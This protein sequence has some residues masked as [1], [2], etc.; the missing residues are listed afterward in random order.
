MGSYMREFATQFTQFN[1]SSGLNQINSY[2]QLPSS[3]KLNTS[4]VKNNALLYVNTIKPY[5]I[6]D[7]T[8]FSPL[9]LQ[10]QN[11]IYAPN[12]TVSNFSGFLFICNLG[13]ISNLTF[14]KELYKVIILLCL[15]QTIK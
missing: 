10:G 3:N 5:M 9:Y 1:G 13:A 12:S 7:E 11:Q 4:F 8:I 6:K 2:Y 15:A 14:Q